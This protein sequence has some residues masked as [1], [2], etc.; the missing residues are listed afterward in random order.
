MNLLLLVTALLPWAAS[1]VAAFTRIFVAVSLLS[2]EMQLVTLSGIGTLYTL[3]IVNGALAALIAGWQLRT[4]ARFVKLGWLSTLQP[5]APWS[6]VALLGSVVLL[7]NVWLPLEA[8][9]PYHLDR[10]AQIERLGTVGHDPA[11]DPKINILGWVY[12]LVLADVRQIP[13]VGSAL[14]KLHGLFGLLLYI[15]TLAVVHTLLRPPSSR[16]PVIALL[17]VAPIFHQF[18]LIKNDLFVA[19]P[20]LVGLSWLIA[21]ARSASW[22]EAAWAGWLV[23][24]VAGYK[25]TSIPLFLIMAGGLLAARRSGG[26]RPV[27]GLALGG[28]AGIVASGLLLTLFENARWYGDPFASGAIAEIGNRTSSLAEAAESIARFGIS[29]LDLGLL[30]PTWWPDRGR[31]GGTFG[32]PF[33]WATVVLVL[34][35]RRSRDARWALSIAALH[36]LSFAAVF[37]DADLTHRLALAPALLVIAVALPFTDSSERYSRWTR[38]ALVPVLALSSAQILR[39]AALYLGRG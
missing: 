14:V 20:A 31:W 12:E 1:P 29:L 8:A 19:A 36:F 37:F 13:V 24:L 10:V 22:N 3:P 4:G 21:R 30:T 32:L 38:L 2:V 6:A 18:V 39:S 25:L 26:W 27:G 33:I 34:H 9:D 35:C 5:P 15:L 23:A 28:I 7:L 17:V 11:V 16:W